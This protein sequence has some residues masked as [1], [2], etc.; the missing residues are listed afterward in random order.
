MKQIKPT[1]LKKQ[2]ENS[3]YTVRKILQLA[4]VPDSTFSNWL[5]G[6]TTININTYNKIIKA[7]NN[8]KEGKKNE[9]KI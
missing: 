1:E 6:K 7:Y 9:T 3:G 5:H 8:L 2:I 4:G